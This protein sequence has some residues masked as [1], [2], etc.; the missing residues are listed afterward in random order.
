MSFLLQSANDSFISNYFDAITLKWVI[1]NANPHYLLFPAGAR[2]DDG[3]GGDNEVQRTMLELINQ[4]DG[5]DPRGNIKVLMATNRYGMML[6][7]IPPRALGAKA[8]YLLVCSSSSSEDLTLFKT[9]TSTTPWNQA[10]CLSGLVWGPELLVMHPS[11]VLWYSTPFWGV[12]LTV[13]VVQSLENLEKSG[14]NFGSW[15]NWKSL[16]ILLKSQ[17]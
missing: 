4:L 5:F 8:I 11:F 14:N 7:V 13:M 6:Y 10:T 3:A 17:R 1:Y 9:S 15:K 16:G 2:F 12:R